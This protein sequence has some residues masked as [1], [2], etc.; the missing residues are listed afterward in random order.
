[1]KEITN[2]FI[3]NVEGQFVENPLYKVARRA[4]LKIVLVVLLK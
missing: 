2:N 4:L 3:E 1:M